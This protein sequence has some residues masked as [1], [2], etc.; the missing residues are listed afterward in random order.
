MRAER[1]KVWPTVIVEIIVVFLCVA[2]AAV[3]ADLWW[4]LGWYAVQY[5]LTIASNLALTRFPEARSEGFFALVLLLN[6]LTG[7]NFA[8]LPVVLWQVD[9]NVYK[10]AVIALLA[11]QT[12]N[13]FLSRTRVWQNTLCYLLPN[14][15]AI[16]LIACSF[17]TP[18]YEAH[19][20]IISMVIALSL[21]TYLVFSAKQAYRRHK[22]LERTRGELELVRR[23]EAIGRLTGGIAHDFNNLLFVVLGNLEALRDEKEKKSRIE[24]IDSAIRAAERGADLTRKMLRFARPANFKLRNVRLNELVQDLTQ[25]CKRTMPANITIRTRLDPNL[26]NALTDFS[27]A[28]SALLNLLLNA[29]DAMPSG[30]TITVTTGTETFETERRV[31]GEGVLEPG[32]YVTISV[33]DTG[34]GITEDRLSKIFEP[35]ATDKTTGTGLGLAMTSVFMQKTGGAVSVRSK[36]DAGSV[37]TLYFRASDERTEARPTS[38]AKALPSRQANT[39]LL[40]VEDD[41]H[42]R[43]T[44]IR[45]L[46][47]LGYP[48]HSAQ[49]GDSAWLLAQAN[50]TFDILITDVVMPG[51]LQGPDL[52]ARLRDIR[53]DLPVIFI[54][55]HDFGQINTHPGVRR[56]DVILSKPIRKDQ[57]VDAIQSALRSQAAA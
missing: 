35:F 55:G 38:P 1:L 43:A 42:V 18:E 5:S 14:C 53:P 52:A 56:G 45:N 47:Q 3:L 16:I 17:A 6:F 33:A 13:T 21:L 2:V 37:F 12:L 41:R 24:M 20:L 23:A 50:S 44:L 31:T 28:E 26:R 32:S 8:I 9:S 25:F 10:F 51:R 46:R 48:I 19:D 30:G 11:G 15:G 27:S 36:P 57:L 29:R 7:A 39:R 49:N 4:L 22:E 54:S 34:L 40:V